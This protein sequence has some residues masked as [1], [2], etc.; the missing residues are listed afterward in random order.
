MPDYE[1]KEWNENN[2][3]VEIIAYTKEAYHAKKYAFVSDFARFWILYHH[4]GLYFDTDVELIK[5]ID[6]IISKGAFM[7]C[8]NDSSKNL[9]INVNPGLG[10][11]AEPKLFI[12]KL[13]LDKYTHL[14]FINDNN[15]YNIKT[16]VEYT[17]ELL[18]QQGLKE[19]HGIQNVS[20]IFIY[21]SDYFC[22]INIITKK[23]HITK[24]SRSIHHFM[25]SWTNKTL[26]DIIKD[27]IRLII[28]E[29]ILISINQIKN[30]GYIFF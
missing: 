19:Q 27:R 26:I 30:R 1:I 21:P 15:T 9:E 6:D 8:E 25:N 20:S 11:G 17:T 22:P 16:V 3:D 5:P 12:Y 4:G 23:L 18:K 14:S 28:P 24:N 7:G 2:F 10:L 29:K 13:L